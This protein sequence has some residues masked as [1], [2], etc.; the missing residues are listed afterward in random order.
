MLPPSDEGLPAAAAADAAAAVPADRFG[1]ALRNLQQCVQKQ[2]FDNPQGGLNQPG[3]GDPVRYQGRGVRPVAPALRRAGAPQLVHP[4]GRDDVSRPRRGD[5]QYSQ[6]D[7]TIT[8]V[9]ILQPA[10]I[11]GFNKAAFGAITGSS[12]TEPL[13]PEYPSDKA[14]FTVTF[15]YSEDPDR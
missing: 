8:D 9:A 7:G 15:Y 11:D 3:A 1:E 6:G 13:P 12:P 2:T 4:A 5:V 10:S 14:F